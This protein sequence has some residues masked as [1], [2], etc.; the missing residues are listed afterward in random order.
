[1]C[2]GDI[3]A[4]GAVFADGKPIKLGDYAHRLYTGSETQNPDPKIEAIEGAGHAP[5]YRGLAYL[6]FDDMPLAAFGNRIPVITVEVV[7]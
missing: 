5:A 2:E 3:T 7:R 6:V 4:I 1:L